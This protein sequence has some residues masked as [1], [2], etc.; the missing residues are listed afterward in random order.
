[1]NCLEGD[2]WANWSGLATLVSY[3]GQEVAAS[4]ARVLGNASQTPGQ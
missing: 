3:T 1:M 4:L 2:G